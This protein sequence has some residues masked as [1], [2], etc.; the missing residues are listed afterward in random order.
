MEENMFQLVDVSLKGRGP[1]TVF[2]PGAFAAE[3][4]REVSART[5]Y[6]HLVRLLCLA[7]LPGSPMVAPE[8]RS[9]RPPVLPTPQKEK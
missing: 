8:E 2:A 9:E 1:F 5:F 6:R 3:R 7:V 4:Q